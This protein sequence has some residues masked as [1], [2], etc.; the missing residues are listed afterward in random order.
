RSSNLTSPT[1]IPARSAAIPKK[2]RK[3]EL[4]PDAIRKSRQG[5][6]V[7]ARENPPGRWISHLGRGTF[8]ATDAQI[9]ANRSNAARSTGPRTDVGKAKAARN[10]ATRGGVSGTG[11][12]LSPILSERV[13][14]FKAML[15]AGYPPHNDYD[16]LLIE[17]AAIARALMWECDERL[18]GLSESQ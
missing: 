7:T 16:C 14:A 15:I 17:D 9:D 11:K 4:E 18:S 5:K 13:E 1:Q 6:L 10:S 12:A 2:K 3:T 8:M